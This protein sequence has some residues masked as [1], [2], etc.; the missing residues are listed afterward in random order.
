MLATAWAYPTR[1]NTELAGAAHKE[2]AQC[3]SPHKLHQH[4]KNPTYQ[5]AV[6]HRISNCL[7]PID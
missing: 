7:Q 2:C 4:H 6:Q 1:C 3:D 5:Q